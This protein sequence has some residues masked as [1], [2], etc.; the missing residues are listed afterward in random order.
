M[1]RFS[2]LVLVVVCGLVG[3]PYAQA[4]TTIGSIQSASPYV[5][6][7]N[8]GWFNLNPD[9]GGLIISD[10]AIT[11]YAWNRRYGWIAF[12]P[13]NSGGVTNDGEGNLGGFAWI[14][15]RGWLPMSGVVID[16]NGVFHGIAGEEN[17][18]VGQVSFNCDQCA[19]S[20][21]WRPL[22]VRRRQ[23]GGGGIVP[24]QA[25]P[26]LPVTS[27]VQPEVIPEPVITPE[28]PVIEIKD[29]PQSSGDVAG[30]AN[31]Q[32]K[33]GG[34]ATINQPLKLLP[35]E[36]GSITR[37]A[38]NEGQVKINVF[39]GSA[40]IGFTTDVS[41]V[42]ADLQNYDFSVASV[43]NFFFDVV[44]F[45]DSGKA[46]PS[47]HAPLRISLPLPPDAQENNFGVYR[48]DTDARTWNLVDQVAVVEDKAIFYTTELGRF[49]VLSAPGRPK[50]I[51]PLVIP[52]KNN[53]I[54]PLAVAIG[55]LAA[56][57]VF[58]KF[59]RK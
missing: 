29:S 20:T 2:L 14:S 59:K 38:G 43:G 51:A 22:S 34:K 21:D 31:G 35:A 45:D 33:S 26:S 10:T 19:V 52:Q 56:A 58:A 57:Y 24:G 39:T 54:A 8:M 11:G 41:P 12:G 18:S 28:P 4:S 40:D 46:L 37:D 47:F 23:G 49:A 16:A 7:E 9:E 13:L 36:A 3:A 5:W 32:D 55:A 50:R 42:P 48:F 17:S 30:P 1:K 15:G 6:G 44:A 25:T 53:T 27:V